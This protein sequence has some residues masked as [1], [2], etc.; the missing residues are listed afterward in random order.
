M[1][2]IYFLFIFAVLASMT[3]AFA[4]TGTVTVDFE[5]TPLADPWENSGFVAY[6]SSA[7]SGTQSAYRCETNS[8]FGQ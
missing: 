7:N 8:V 3:S 6:T 4:A 2:K 5:G 1:K